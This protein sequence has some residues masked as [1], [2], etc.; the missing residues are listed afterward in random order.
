MAEANRTVKPS[1]TASRP[2]PTAKCVLPTPGGPSSSKAS[3]L[4]IQRQ[5]ARSRICLGSSD[6][7]ASNS[8]PS[9]VRTKGNLGNAETHL[10]APLL[11]MTDL[12]L[13]EQVERVADR[14]VATPGLVQKTV[15]P[16]AHRLQ[17]ECVSA[18]RTAGRAR[19]SP[20]TSHG[21]FVLGQWPQQLARRGA[22]DSPPA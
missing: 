6:G 1:R 19:R 3:P 12:G 4:A 16:V 18:C 5:V 10:D 14:Q 13:A 20:G 11:A 22:E 7:W 9:R 8:K 15:E 2:R 17:A 21:L